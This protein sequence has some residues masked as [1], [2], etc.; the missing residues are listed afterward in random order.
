LTRL[1]GSIT[2]IAASLLRLLILLS[3]RF[4]FIAA[5]TQSMNHLRKNASQGLLQYHLVIYFL[6][7]IAPV[8]CT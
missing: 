7:N 1:G 3:S 8:L 5:A 2:S 6:I 4:W